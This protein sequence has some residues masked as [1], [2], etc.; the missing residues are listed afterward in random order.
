MS[1][2]DGLRTYLIAQ[3]PLTALIGTTNPRIWGGNVIPQA[4]SLP[5][6]TYWESESEHFHHMTGASGR[7]IVMMRIDSWATTL[8][9]ALALAE[10]VRTE[11]QG[12][13]G[14]MGSDNVR[15]CHFYGQNDEYVPPEAGGKIGRYLV[16]Q[17]WKIGYVES[18]PTF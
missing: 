2:T 13:R 11:M 7:A 3:A 6:V 16:W 1:V 5:A 18:V 8:V 15:F 17:E 14:A 9:A 12:Y 4:E 10:V